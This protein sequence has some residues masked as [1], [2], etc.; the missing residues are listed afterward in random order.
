VISVPT[1]RPEQVARRLDRIIEQILHERSDQGH[2]AE[3]HHADHNHE[4][5]AADEVAV[6]EHL[7]PDKRLI[8]GQRMREEVVEAGHRDDRL[9]PDFV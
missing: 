7:E 4:N 1:P 2:R 5:A 8:C 9:D 3:Q 6:P